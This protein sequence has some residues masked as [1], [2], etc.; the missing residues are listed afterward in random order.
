MR[1]LKEVRPRAYCQEGEADRR[2]DCAAGAGACERIGS[3]GNFGFW[4]ADFGLDSRRQEHDQNVFDPAF[5]VFIRQSKS[6]P[7]D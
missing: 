5:V 7:A 1:A 6:G 3:L 2:D 4:I